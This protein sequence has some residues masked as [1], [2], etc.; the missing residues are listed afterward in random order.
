MTEK[1]VRTLSGIIDSEKNPDTFIQRE[2]DNFKRATDLY[3]KTRQ[4]Q[5]RTE[6]VSIAVLSDLYWGNK[7]ISELFT[8]PR[9]SAKLLSQLEAKSLPYSID[10]QK[11]LTLIGQTSEARFKIQETILRYNRESQESEAKLRMEHDEKRQLP[12]NKNHTPIDRIEQNDELIMR[13]RKE[14]ADI[15][16]KFA[17]E[18]AIKAEALRK[19]V[20]QQNDTAKSLG[21]FLE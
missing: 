21:M 16:A 13:I 9:I 19:L 7:T 12:V 6:L 10:E 3:E 17:L 5:E 15:K 8:C 4:L 20:S 11:L 1:G 14:N 2:A 18:I